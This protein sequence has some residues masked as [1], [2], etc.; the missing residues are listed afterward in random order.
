LYEHLPPAHADVACVGDM[1]G[2]PHMPQF[3]VSVIVSVHLPSHAVMP[4][5]HAAP[6]V[7]P[8]QTVPPVHAL[9]HLPQFELSVCVLVH[10]PLQDVSPPVQDA[11]PQVPLEH[12]PP[13]QSLPHEPQFELSVCVS[14]QVPPHSVF[15]PGQLPPLSTPP[16]LSKEPPLLAHASGTTAM[17]ASGTKRA[18]NDVMVL[19][20]RRRASLERPSTVGAAI[21]EC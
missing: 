4:P 3:I 20:K 13:S 8:E 1:H 19:P 17:Q 9:P 15:V 10:A 5:V 2:C 18:R 11:P 12:V 14:T 6:Q 16:S 7:P 21:W